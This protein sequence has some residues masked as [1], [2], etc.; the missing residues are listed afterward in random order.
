[1]NLTLLVDLE[2]KKN[3]A[4][5]IDATLRYLEASLGASR[6][7][8]EIPE[9]DLN[10]PADS[11]VD[12]Y[13]R[14]GEEEFAIEHTLIEPF[15][16]HM[17]VSSIT[18][19]LEGYFAELMKDL[20]LPFSVSV[21]LSDGWIESRTTDRERKR[22]LKDLTTVLRQNI[23]VLFKLQLDDQYHQF[24]V[25]GEQF[26]V[27]RDQME[28]VNGPLG[29]CSIYLNASD[30]PRR[31]EERLER[32]FKDKA[33]KL[34]RFGKQMNKILILENRDIQ[35][36]GAHSI[37]IVLRQIY[38]R[39]NI[40]LDYIFFIVNMTKCYLYPFYEKGIWKVYG[41][42]GLIRVSHF[43]EAELSERL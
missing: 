5:C 38:E 20:A 34:D 37:H 39:L 1:M 28:D 17:K 30:V 13:A 19:G 24:E 32:A 21:G 33:F 41:P 40:Q 43:E 11:R 31:R 16:N 15:N 3:E 18:R 27:F 26:Y 42:N 35:L 14:I 10:V 22:L 25:E 7:N 2:M 6:S 23:D 12:Y 29:I 4:K 8:V 9:N 36:T